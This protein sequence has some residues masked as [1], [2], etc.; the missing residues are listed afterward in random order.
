MQLVSPQ[1]SLARRSHITQMPLGIWVIGQRPRNIRV[2]VRVGLLRTCRPAGDGATFPEGWRL[3]GRVWF[4]GRKEGWT[5]NSWR[6]KYSELRVLPARNGGERMV[7]GYCP[8]PACSERLSELLLIDQVV[9]KFCKNT[10]FL[11]VGLG[12]NSP[13]FFPSGFIEMWSA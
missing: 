9:S 11:Y 5:D 12:K 4:A 3:T 6:R 2:V 1:V 10:Y 8:L 13:C 7:R